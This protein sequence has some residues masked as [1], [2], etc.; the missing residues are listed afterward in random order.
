MS[1]DLCLIFYDF[2]FFCLI[3]FWY[4]H[5]LLL[6]FCKLF[7][8]FHVQSLLFMLSMVVYFVCVTK[9]LGHFPISHGWPSWL[10]CFSSLHYLI[11]QHDWKCFFIANLTK[12]IN[13]LQ[14]KYFD[15][16]WNF[17]IYL[18][19]TFIVLHEFQISSSL[20]LLSLDLGHW[21]K[22]KNIT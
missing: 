4:V 8:P 12:W 14:P 7:Y 9:E 6:W 11:D 19:L 5:Y 17:G 22:P 10:H 18:L 2:F 1:I 13:H 3:F 20:S 21:V 16:T 15:N